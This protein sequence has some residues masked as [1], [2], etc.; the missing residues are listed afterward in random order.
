[1]I[2]L[3][4]KQ[5]KLKKYKISLAIIKKIIR[6]NIVIIRKIIDQKGKR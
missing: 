1:M 4:K 6:I 2:K 3:S 5:K